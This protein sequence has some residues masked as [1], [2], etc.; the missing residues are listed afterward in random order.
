MQV[1]KVGVKW[2][3]LTDRLY[4]Q[5]YI[6]RDTSTV[7]PI[8]F[9]KY[10]IIAVVSYNSPLPNK[11]FQ[12]PS[13][14]KLTRTHFLYLIWKVIVRLFLHYNM[15]VYVYVCGLNFASC[16]RHLS[17]QCDVLLTLLHISRND[18]YKI[19]IDMNCLG[20]WLCFIS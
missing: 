19:N 14:C 9:S 20:I 13:S 12:S 2:P 3:T 4:I 15:H 16:I 7:Q 18:P 8:I 10:I 5:V 1:D 11:P 6:S 17:F